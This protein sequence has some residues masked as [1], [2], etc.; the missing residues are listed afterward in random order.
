MEGHDHSLLPDETP[1]GYGPAGHAVP[2]GLALAANGLRFVPAETRFEPT[3]ETDWEFQIANDD[4][5]V[6]SFDRAHGESSHLIVVR[7]DLS[8][9]QHRHPS[10][11]ND[12]T[13]NV[14]DLELP[15]PGVYRAFVDVVVDGHPT[16]LGYDLFAP[17]EFDVAPR[18]TSSRMAHADGYDVR[19]LVDDVSVDDSV[20]LEFEFRRDA[21]LVSHLGEYLG[22]RGHLV[23]LRE[24]D[25][26]Y[27]HVHPMETDL[28]EGRVSFGARFPTPG[29]YRLFL[30]ARPDDHL[31]TTHFDVQV[32]E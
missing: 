12:G 26:G 28:E 15:D 19:L 22:A 5:I 14:Q 8:R 9:F 27:L 4:T 2:G 17:G 25:L 7:R 32:N 23:A 20:Q 16:T 11:S 10:L 13:W 24:G 6:T 29:R 31:V 30:Q 1:Q 18:P 21:E 3:V